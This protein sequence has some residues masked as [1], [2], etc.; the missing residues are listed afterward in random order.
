MCLLKANVCEL[1]VALI[2]KLEESQ[3]PCLKFHCLLFLDILS[4]ILTYLKRH[5]Y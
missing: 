2:L 4:K 1:G 3:D 5:E